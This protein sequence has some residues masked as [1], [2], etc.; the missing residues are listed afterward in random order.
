MA[1]FLQSIAQSVSSDTLTHNVPDTISVSRDSIPLP[2]S[3]GN[4]VMLEGKIDY[5]AADSISFDIRKKM[6]YMYGNAIIKYQDIKLIAAVIIIDFN[7]STVYANA[8]TDSTGKTIGVPDFT[9]G[10][11][12]FK[13]NSL[14]YN[15]NTK[16]GLIKNVITEEGGGYLHASVIKKLDN[17]VSETGPGMF[18]TCDLEH[19][20]FAIKYSR[21]KVIPGDKIVTGPA[22]LSIEDVPLPLVLP[23]GL[24]PNKKGRSSGIKIPTW[25]EMANL[26]FYLM[27]GGYYFGLSDHFD[28]LLIGDVY[29][30]GSWALKPLVNY[31]KR[32]KYSGSFSLKYAT[33][34]LG[35][36]GTSDYS[37]RKDF[38][39]TWSH[40]QDPKARP[41]GIFSASVQ[42]GSSK[43]NSYNPS[44]VSDYLTNSFSSSISYD[45]RLGDN[46]NLTTSA[47]H[48]Q[49][50]S[51]RD[52][53]IT[54]PEVSFGFN[55]IYPFKH[56][57]Q[58]G[59]P[60]WY[61]SIS[62]TYN[63]NLRNEIST[64]DSMLFKPESIDK[65]VYGIKHTIPLSGSFKVLK[66]LTWSH[67]INYTE[68]WYPK[69]INKTWINE[70]TVVNGDTLA[71]HVQVDTISGFRTA[72]DYNYSSS[73]STTLY[74][75]LQFRKGPVKALRHVVRPSVGFS[76]QPDFGKAKFGYYK[77]VQVD[78]AGRQQSYSVFGD[79]T[80]YRTLYG[81][82]GTGES[83]SVNFSLSNNLEMK[84][85][86]KSDTITGLQKVMLI[87]NLSFST[88][89][90]L[91][92]DSMRWSNLN[93]N[94]RTTL[95]KKIQ[96][97]YSS[98]FSPY[99]TNI[100]GIPYN[101]FEWAVN[102]KV[103]RFINSSWNLSLGY[104]LKSESGKSKTAPPSNATE[105]E[106][107][108]IKNNPQQFIDW[109]N[110]W[111]LHF[112]YNFRYNSISMVTGERQKIV[113]Q[114]FR[115]TGD[116][117]VTE[118]WKIS[119][120]S[121][122]DF[123]SKD[124]AYTSVSIYRNLHCWEMRFNW[125]PYGYQKSW[126]FQINVKSSVLQDLKLTKKKDFRDNL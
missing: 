37:K 66:F 35:V 73:V 124:F 121:G 76:Y 84:V 106:V 59:K 12:N 34:V 119:A 21:A 18:T 71:P 51:S 98:S 47:R 33:N 39:V 28:M 31:K 11:L 50:T 87:D 91:V 25:G 20:H 104:D 58:K 117:S 74:G 81:V 61:E 9:Q 46:A 30:R 103:F 52:V 120:Q 126:N 4:K 105:A 53:T 63:L 45:M 64:K 88:S 113:V 16:K 22:Y 69:T 65:F 86:S 1:A 82:P 43:Y 85:K 68:R 102:K 60:A 38:F 93:I 26:G 17:N 57:V 67:N 109:D 110:P 92:K 89:Y 54:L 55:R 111:N 101:K 100:K 96:V 36:K 32:Y 83:G 48:S 5:A 125:I 97:S 15:F 107:E 72:R 24:F 114:T 41:N 44:T 108:E 78:T 80:Y 13:S 23:F 90:D 77:T 79:G 27:D 40:R 3:S 62:I 14:S 42:A 95:F 7:K 112:D 116:L 2:K 118:K 75:M 10:T 8:I 70:T 122:Y 49:N 29:S 123:E 6:A 19:P 56:K 115:V 94:A 99:A